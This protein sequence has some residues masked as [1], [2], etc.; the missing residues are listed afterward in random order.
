MKIQ[1]RKLFAIVITEKDASDF[2]RIIIKSGIGSDDQ[3]NYLSIYEDAAEELM[4]DRLSKK[5]VMF[6]FKLTE[7]Q[8]KVLDKGIAK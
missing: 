8:L 4:I 6:L 3:P 7:E 1:V 2:S 5:E